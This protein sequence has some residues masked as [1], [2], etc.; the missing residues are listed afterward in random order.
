MLY[1]IAAK[2]LLDLDLTAAIHMM[3]NNTQVALIETEKLLITMVEVEL[4]RRA[5]AG[6]YSGKFAALSHFFGLA[7]LP[8]STK[9]S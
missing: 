8:L 4:K 5:A 2:L 3:Y 9:H 1:G 7:P 6:E